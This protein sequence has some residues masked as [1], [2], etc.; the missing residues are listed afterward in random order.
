MSG[1][2]APK[3]IISA[4]QALR[5]SNSLPHAWSQE[6]RLTQ[7]ILIYTAEL[8]EQLVEQQRKKRKKTLWNVFL[9]RG[10]RAGKSMQ[11]IGYE[12]QQKKH[13]RAA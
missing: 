10:L 12:W 13:G 9:S 5:K 6:S 1:Y 3:R 7:R 4:V 2:T 8:L 11:Q